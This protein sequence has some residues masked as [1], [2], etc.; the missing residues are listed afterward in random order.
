MNI[1]L[2]LF[3]LQQGAM[4]RLEDPTISTR[5]IVIGLI[6]AFVIIGGLIILNATS[7]KPG[8]S[9]AKKG[10]VGGGSSGSGGYS[11][12]QSMALHKI[13]RTIGLN[14]DQTKMLDFVFRLDD[15]VEP[16]RSINTPA[17]LDRHFRKAYRVIE[18]AATLSAETQRKLGVLFSTRNMLENSI[19]S[20]VTSTKML[21]DDTTFMI[22]TGKEKVNV[23]LVN[24]KGDYILVEPPRNVLGSQIKIQRGTRL[25]V[26][27]FNKSNKGFS[28][29]TRVIGYS[30]KDGRATMLI[31]HSNH[32]RFLS[33]RRYRR[34]QATIPVSFFLV[35][36]EGSGKKQRLIVDKRRFQG[37]IADVSVGGCS[38]KV[39]SPV[40][41][42]ARFKIEFMA[43]DSNVA[44]LGQV[45]RTNR[46]GMNTIIHIKFLKLSQKSMNAIN[47]FVYEYA[48]E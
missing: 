36:V 16:E 45:L 13:A 20:S 35:L 9:G 5:D 40:Q 19:L 3:P 24:T 21:R 23:H 30:N 46:T 6:V 31:A 39:M 42:G 7:K 27:F 18:N 47:S 4:I 48:R 25:I 34:R 10:G 22:N 8:I 14:R 38:I 15:V 11:F 26:L 12:F 2:S 33:Q 44:A 41:V 1:L 32:L 28:F 43:G 17:L 29:E 37:N